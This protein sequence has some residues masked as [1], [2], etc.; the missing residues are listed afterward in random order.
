MD[1]GYGKPGTGLF[2]MGNE[3]VPF[4]SHLRQHLR[5]AALLDQRHIVFQRF[6]CRPVREIEGPLLL[7]R[8]VTG[9]RE[10][11]D[12]AAVTEIEQRV[13]AFLKSARR[14]AP[15]ADVAI[16]VGLVR[17][18]GEQSLGGGRLSNS[19]PKPALSTGVANALEPRE[20]GGEVLLRGFAKRVE[21]NGYRGRPAPRV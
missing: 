13:V 12:Q 14:V 17:L 7:V 3:P 10:H 11:C 16:Q 5:T 2:S 21:L 9:H 20:Q 6:A 1:E 18:D 8:H 4:L 19:P 15:F